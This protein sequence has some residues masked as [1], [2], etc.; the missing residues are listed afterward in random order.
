[1]DWEIIEQTTQGGGVQ[2]VYVEFTDHFSKTHRR[3]YDFPASANVSD[4]IDSRS[5]SVEHGL[6]DLEEETLRSQVEN[7][8]LA[9]MD[10][11]PERPYADSLALRKRRFYRR[12]LRY[13]ANNRDMKLTRLVF[14]PVWYYLKFES[15][16]TAQQIADYLDISLAKLAI[17][18]SRFQAIHDN[19]TFIDADD[20]YV[21]GVD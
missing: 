1:M 7:G 17:I 15:E 9:A 16:Y 18:N 13:V 19:L 12:L 11:E 4:E 20:N 6:E 21:G 5:V 8:I 10:V 2:R 3:S 14:Y